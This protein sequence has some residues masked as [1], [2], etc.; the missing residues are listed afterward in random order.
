MHDVRSQQYARKLPERRLLPKADFDSF[1]GETKSPPIRKH[2]L[3]LIGQRPHE[4]SQRRLGNSIVS[5]HN[6]TMYLLAKFSTYCDQIWERDSR[7]NL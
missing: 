7:V 5:S 2:P 4:L 1:T 3:R 6:G